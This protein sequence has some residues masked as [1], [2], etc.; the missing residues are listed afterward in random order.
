MGPIVRG[1][2]I[3]GFAVVL[4]QSAVSSAAPPKKVYDRCVC[5][6]RSQDNSKDLTSSDVKHCNL[7]G[8][9]CKF[10]INGVTYKGKL[11]SCSLCEKGGACKPV[12]S[13]PTTPKVE[14]K[15]PLSGGTSE[16]AAAPKNPGGV[17]GGTISR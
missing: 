7:N 5:T 6:C 14:P 16:P 3:L 8:R 11:D 1:F 12:A 15:A 2:L 13:V 9:D 10:T 17:G 4:G